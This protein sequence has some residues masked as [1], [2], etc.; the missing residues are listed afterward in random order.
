MYFDKFTKKAQKVID[1]S[2]KCAKDLGHSVVGTEHILLGLIKVEEGIASKILI[3]LGIE[4]EVVSKQIVDIYGIGIN[5]NTDDI[6]LSP[7]SRSILDKSIIFLNKSKNKLID[8][9]HILLALS[10][11][12][13]SIAIKI[14]KKSGIDKQL[15]EKSIKEYIDIDDS[16]ELIVNQIDIEDKKKDKLKISTLEKYAINLNDNAKNNKIDPLIGREKEVQRIIQVLSRRTKNNPVVIG[17]PGVGKTAIIEGL[18]IKIEEKDVPKSLENKIIYNLDISGVLAGAKYRGEF[19]ER[20]KKIID[21][22]I[23]AKEII[24]FIDEIHT[25]V[26]AG[27]TGENPMDASNILKPVLSRGD[28]QVIGATTIDEYRKNIEKDV[29]LERRLQPIIVEEPTKEDAIKIL[30]GLKNKYEK[31]HNVKITDDAIKQAVELSSRYITDRYLP[32]KAVDII[33]ESASRVS[34]NKFK[35]KKGK[36]IVDSNIV[37]EVVEL[38]T[39]IPISKIVKSEGNKLLN[40]EDILQERVIGQNEA[41]KAISKA[42]RR[43]RSGIKDPKKPIGSFLFLG[44]TGVG[45]TELC[46]A[47]AESH[48]GNEDKIVRIDMSEYMEKHSV[49]RLIGSPPGY[50]GHD[51]GGQL[52]ES[53]R[54]HPYSVVLFDEI[55]KAH[56]DIFNILLQ[57]LDEGRLTDSKGR[58]V[59]FKNTIIIMT[60]NLGATSISNQRKTGFSIGNNE[61]KIKEENYNDMKDKIMEEVKIRFRPEFI[62]RIDDIVVFHKLS[63]DNLYDIVKIMTK[64]LIKRLKKMDIELDIEETVIKF[65][66]KYGIDLEY[67]ARPL[68]RVI[69][70]ELED[71]LSEN[72]LSENIKKGDYI[73]AKMVNEKIVFEPNLKNR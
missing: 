27:A 55:E 36:R 71:S 21:E 38:W 59:D 34:I 25:I 7:R 6:F 45:K 43:S 48:F 50:I 73:I 8:T 66:A 31:H 63:L 29:A 4:S 68:K 33:D 23:N 11:E 3:R 16:I 9:E 54:S 10:Q 47:L 64:D 13:D 22:A 60:S 58:T 51:D 28:I 62:N 19:E 44:P 15:L 57:I 1:I 52:T 26:G 35:S 5:D 39:G 69:Q 18:A 30:N 65:I 42:I 12:E 46:K 14:L 72:I 32:D 41:I 61:S 56:E 17:D 40:L 67:G 53:V 70:K 49:S 2:I 37:S 24:L 20:I